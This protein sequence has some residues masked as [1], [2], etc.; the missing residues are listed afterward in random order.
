MIL[1]IFLYGCWPFLY[2]LCGNSHSSVHSC[3][4]ILKVFV[5][6]VYLLIFNTYTYILYILN[7]RLLYVLSENILFQFS[8]CL[9]TFLIISASARRVWILMRPHLSIFPFHCSGFCCHAWDSVAQFKDFVLA[10][11]FKLLT[12]L[13]PF[14]HLY[15]VRSQL[16]PAAC[17][18]PLVGWTSFAEESYSF[19][20]GWSWYSFWRS[21]VSSRILIF[22]FSEVNSK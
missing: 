5:F 11:I 15:K 19:S 20:T 4:I 22:I 12:Q 9:F 6:A 8:N 10:F 16:H 1:S 2:F 7:I 3:W 21:V 14:L 13:N 17:G 18:C